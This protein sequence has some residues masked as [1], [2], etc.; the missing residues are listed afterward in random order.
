MTF[1]EHNENEQEDRNKKRLKRI[2]AFAE[3]IDG[4]KRIKRMEHQKHSNDNYPEFS[5]YSNSID[6]N[7]KI[8][9]SNK[10]DPVEKVALYLKWVQQFNA[11]DSS[12]KKNKRTALRLLS[13]IF[14]RFKA[15]VQQEQRQ[16]VS[17]TPH[18]VH[19][20][21]L[22]SEHAKRAT[23]PTAEPTGK[24]HKGKTR[25]PVTREP[26]PRS[27]SLQLERRR[28]EE[29]ERKRESKHETKHEAKT[30]A[31]AKYDKKLSSF[32]QKFEGKDSKGKSRI[33]VLYNKIRKEHGGSK[34]IAVHSGKR[35]GQVNAVERV[36]GELKKEAAK[37][38]G[39]MT[40]KLTEVKNNLEHLIKALEK[41]EMG[42]TFKTKEGKKKSALKELVIE[43]KSEIVALTDLR[44]QMRRGKRVQ[45]QGI[46]ESS[47]VDA[48][49]QERPNRT[50]NR[51]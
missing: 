3:A 35:K 28:P 34:Q 7:Y 27:A 18:K 19:K 48:A 39:N 20:T 10:E 25:E 16:L 17:Y 42:F 50:R 41:E 43:I 46:E 47:T 12:D 23:Q 5:K 36:I 38:A 49:H 45:F 13:N 37:P 29:E 2:V 11:K 4:R 1:Y 9:K 6:D 31:E 21:M 8:L 26:V 44:K 40:L 51:R 33:D 14:A 30:E 32:I 22:T 24:G 15:L